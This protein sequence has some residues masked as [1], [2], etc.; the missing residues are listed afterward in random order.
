MLP[1]IIILAT[2]GTIVSSGSSP[3][4]TTGYS[5]Q[6]IRAE[7]IADAIP[8]L[9]DM[10]DIEVHTVASIDSSS[11]TFDI[12]KSLLAALE[13]YAAREDVRGI[14]VMHGTDT[15]E[16]TA[17]F[18]NL[19][20][21]T[22]KPIVFTGAMRPATAI[23]ADGALNLFNAVCLA[24]SQKTSG[25][26]VVIAMNGMFLSARDATKT[27]TVS[28]ETFQSRLTGFM[29]TIIGEDI[30]LLSLPAKPHTAD[31]V[32]SSEQI[33]K[34]P[35]LPRVD[36]V[37]GFADGDSN[38]LKASRESGPDAIVVAAPGH[39]TLSKQMEAE[40]LRAID[41]GIVVC[42]ASRTGS[43]AVIAGLSRWQKASVLFARTLNP[44]KVRILLQLGLAKYGK[45]KSQLQSLIDMY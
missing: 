2:G 32:F 20:V 13:E 41:Q 45:N 37:Y 24:A 34:L 40:V 29:G 11:I 6:D 4:Q 14:V 27:N 23:S 25:H 35:C 39:G 12:W 30:D 28:V 7:D 5:I 15:M 10:A 44:Q 17:F 21:K 22:H 3:V 42:R 36:I 19:T 43:G 31:T 38:V 8:T 18:M 26:G 33:N 1:K 16:E 9:R